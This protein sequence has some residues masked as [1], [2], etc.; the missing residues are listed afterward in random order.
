MYQGVIRRFTLDQ[1]CLKKVTTMHFFFYQYICC[2]NVVYIPK[3]RVWILCNDQDQKKMRMILL[4]L[5][6]S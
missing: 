2:Y 1:K 5:I 4:R 3:V 6:S